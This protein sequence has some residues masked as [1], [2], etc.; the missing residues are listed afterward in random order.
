MSEHLPGFQSQFFASFCISQISH[1]Q[2][3]RV[4]P[5]MPLVSEDVDTYIFVHGQKQS[6]NFDENLQVKAKLRKIFNGEILFRTSLK[7]LFHILCKIFLNSKVIVKSI[8]DPDDNFKRNPS[9][10]KG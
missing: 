4:N 8:K 7:T 10:S 6:N 3:T 1:S 5:F 9:A 2:H